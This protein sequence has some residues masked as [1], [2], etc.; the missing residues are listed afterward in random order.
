MLKQDLA[1][2]IFI[3][4]LNYRILK[5]SLTKMGGISNFQIEDA[6][7]RI[8]DKDL[9]KNFVGVFPS[10]YMNKFINHAAMIEDKKGKYPFIIANTDS[11][12][13][14]GLH[15]WTILD[16]EPRF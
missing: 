6:I 12:E 11:N 2:I 4:M 15:W 9:S 13:K 16:I 8:G 1:S 3:L 10:N 14:K 5:N 7:K